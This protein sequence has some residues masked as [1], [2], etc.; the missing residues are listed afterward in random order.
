MSTA[1]PRKLLAAAR[2]YR[3]IT[4]PYAS[5]SLAGALFCNICSNTP[6]KSES[7]WDAHVASAQHKANVA[8]KGGIPS[9][10][11]AAAGK[12]NK[13]PAETPSGHDRDGTTTKRLR[14]ARAD[15][16]NLALPVGFFDDDDDDDEEGIVSTGEVIEPDDEEEE[17]KTVDARAPA[18]GPAGS[19]LPADF[20]SSKAASDQ[21]NKM[22]DDTEDLDD[23]WAAFQ[24]DIAQTEE[25]AKGDPSAAAPTA[26]TQSSHT[27][28]AP[29]LS[30]AEIQQQQQQAAETDGA[31]TSRT[32]AEEE[33]EDARAAMADFFDE[34]SSLE[35]RVQKLKQRREMLRRNPGV[36]EEGRTDFDNLHRSNSL[37]SVQMGGM[38]DSASSVS[39]AGNARSISMVDDEDDDD[40]YADDEDMFFRRR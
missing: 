24:A 9:G 36:S 40:D 19:K 6:I 18:A 28:S 31:R 16:K 22:D 15:V 30:A 35:E 37:R 12:S 13:R 1:D 14:T 32:I 29:A 8:R 2:K 39:G 34:Q 11:A 26:N 4:S 27:I 7:L 33:M 5:Y 23:E 17:E 3:R 38:D 25:A 21:P 20:F 10:D